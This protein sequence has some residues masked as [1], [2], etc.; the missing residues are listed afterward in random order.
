MDE[1]PLDRA[2]EGLPFYNIFVSAE[3]FLL[4]TEEPKG[5]DIRP[6]IFATEEGR[7]VLAFDRED[8][9]AQFVGRPAAH[10]ALPGRAL[11]DL[12]EGHGI[13]I[14]LNPDVAPSSQ[15]IPA[16]AVD[17]IAEAQ[18]DDPE[19]RADRI[20]EITAPNVP[21]PL[22]VALDAT[23]AGAVGAAPRA[24]LVATVM[25]DGARGHLL[26]F[27]GA[28]EG[29]EAGLAQAVSE[30]LAFSGLE[31]A[32][33]DV[34]FFGSVDPMSARLSAVGLRFDLPQLAAPR[35]SAPSAP[36]MDPDRPPKLR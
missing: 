9:M 17:W 33:L 15:L 5:D 23:L 8:R 24:Y 19:E 36:G 4:L 11:A 2:P 22:L 34:G 16:E 21:E 32:S 35:S 6:E 10:V 30:A 26:A 7:F 29:A 3:L 27:V 1:T 13:G 20:A 25:E 31:A 12:L 14:A 18:A 28:Q